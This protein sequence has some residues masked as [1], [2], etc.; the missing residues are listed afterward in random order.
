MYAHAENSHSAL[1][2]YNFHNIRLPFSYRSTVSWRHRSKTN[3]HTQHESVSQPH[4]RHRAGISPYLLKRSFSGPSFQ[5]PKN[6]P[7]LAMPS[8]W[9]CANKAFPS[10]DLKPMKNWSNLSHHHTVSGEMRRTI[11]FFHQKNSLLRPMG[12]SASPSS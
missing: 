7:K 8:S 5:I 3:N 11:S 9:P 12:T 6:Q 1:T 4:M 2:P 10:P